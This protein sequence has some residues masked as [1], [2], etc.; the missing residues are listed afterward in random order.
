MG[1]D[2]WKWTNALVDAGLMY[3]S[4]ELDKRII[5][6]ASITERLEHDALYAPYFPKEEDILPIL[7]FSKDDMDELSIIKTDIFKMVDI[8]WAQWIIEGNIEAEWDS[9]LNQLESMGLSRMKEIYQK[10]Y[11]EYLGK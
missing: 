8:K 1:A 4:P 6:P 9:Y 7:K 3:V 11:D 10:Y 5:A 2:E